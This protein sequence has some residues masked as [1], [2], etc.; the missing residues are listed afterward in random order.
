MCL[1]PDHPGEHCVH[2]PQGSELK[3][4]GDRERKGQKPNTGKVLK[5]SWRLSGHWSN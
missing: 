3:C 5:E 4:E 2:P 1:W